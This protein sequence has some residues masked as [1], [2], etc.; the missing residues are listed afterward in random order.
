MTTEPAPT[1]ETATPRT[2]V[3]WAADAV[4]A[5]LLVALE[6]AALL[7][8]FF[9][10][11]FAN[12][13]DTTPGPPPFSWGSDAWLFVYVGVLG[14]LAALASYGLFRARAPFSGSTQGMAAALLAIL[15]V[16]MGTAAYRAAHPQEERP[17]DPGTSGPSR[18]CRS[19]GDNSECNGS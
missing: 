11:A 3:H 6:A 4:L 18:Q 13:D 19:G 17:S 2:P 9:Y 10:A 16:V 5:V 14:L 12:W 8:G 15:L 7:G 1:T